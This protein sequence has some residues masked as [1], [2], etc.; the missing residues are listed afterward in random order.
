[1]TQK[2]SRKRSNTQSRSRALSRSQP[3]APSGAWDFWID[4]GGTFTDVVGRHPDGTLTA[5]KLLSENPE[6]YRDAA[7]QGIRDLLGLAAGEA[8]PPG[9]VGAVKMGT[10]VATNALLERKGERTLLLTT[11]GFGDA[12]RIGYQARPKIFAK[13]IIKP[14]M[15]FERVVEVDERVR[16]DGALERALDL[17]GVRAELERAM[18][19]GVK[20]VAIVFMHAYRYPEHEKRVA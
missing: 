15:L 10:T 18:A 14:E 8:I 3:A 2:K 7:V 11:K 16:A 20:A 12:L 4:R 17:N 19:D 1:M 5:H 6:A 13:H 9:R